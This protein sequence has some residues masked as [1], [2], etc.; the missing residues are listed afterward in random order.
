M[1]G[2]ELLSA[3]GL[4]DWDFVAEGIGKE[5]CDDGSAIDVV[6]GVVLFAL[7]FDGLFARKIPHMELLRGFSAETLLEVE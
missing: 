2:T 4:E 1:C 5:V 6:V 7:R 3:V